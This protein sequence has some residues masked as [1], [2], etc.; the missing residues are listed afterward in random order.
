MVHS[1]DVKIYENLTAL[2]RA[3]VAQSVRVEDNEER[4]LELLRVPDFDPARTVILDSGNE[5]ISPEGETN[6]E[7]VAYEPE[8]VE[9]AV[10]SSSP[11]YLVLTDSYYPG[12]TAEVDGV[13]VT[14]ERANLYF[15]AVLLGEGDHDVVF[16]YQPASA[17]LGLAISLFAWLAWALAFAVVT[18]RIGRKSPSSV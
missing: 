17:R 8:R 2:P 15:R 13:R 14:I 9:L 7:I 6:V 11:G 1:G 18:I 16:R 10:S 5:S 4:A 12:W 3:F